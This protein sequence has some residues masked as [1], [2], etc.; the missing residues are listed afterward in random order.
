MADPKEYVAELNELVSEQ[1]SG[2]IRCECIKLII[3]LGEKIT[4]GLTFIFNTFTN[5]L[6][7]S[8]VGDQAYF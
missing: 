3:S 2:T 4:G 7:K 6:G 8:I 1:A 5:F